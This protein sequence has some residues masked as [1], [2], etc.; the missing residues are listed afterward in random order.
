MEFYKSF[1]TIFDKADV[2]L[3]SNVWEV[4]ENDPNSYLRKMTFILD[5]RC[6]KC[7]SFDKSII[8][9]SHN[10]IYS[11]SEKLKDKDC[12]G[13]AIVEIEDSQ[14][15]FL[16]E[17]KSNFDEKQIFYAFQQSVFSLLKLYHYL[18]YCQGINYSDIIIKVIL[19]CKNYKDEN[20][21]VYVNDIILMLDTLD[22][23]YKKIVY[24]LCAEGKIDISLGQL[25]FLEGMKFYEGIRSKNIEV[26]LKMTE[27]YTDSSIILNLSSVC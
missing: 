26:Y 14:Y 21:R 6:M 7:C 2:D 11:K 20:Q 19:A 18:S 13:L 12:D 27:S 22:E 4:I 16:V 9:N 10:Y 23:S 17:L 8:K 5:E 15:L 24:R 25:P 1:I 3:L